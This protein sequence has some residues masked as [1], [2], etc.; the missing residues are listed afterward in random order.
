[1]KQAMAAAEVRYD[2]ALYSSCLDVLLDF[3]QGNHS[4][5][6]QDRLAS[7]RTSAFEYMAILMPSNRRI[8]RTSWLGSSIMEGIFWSELGARLAA[9]DLSLLKKAWLDAAR[10]IE[11]ELA[12]VFCAS[13]LILKRSAD[14]GVEAVVRPRIVAA[15]R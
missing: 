15:M 12:R 10:V 4:Q 1:M 7:I 9:L 14:G 11:D 6:L 13:K 8:D 5:G 2:A 3:Q